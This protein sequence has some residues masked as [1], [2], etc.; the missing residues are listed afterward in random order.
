[1]GKVS[2]YI[3]YFLIGVLIYYALEAD[4]N[5]DALNKIHSYA[6]AAILVIFILLMAVQFIRKKREE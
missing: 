4:K 1:M 3:I 5:P 6:P 2:R